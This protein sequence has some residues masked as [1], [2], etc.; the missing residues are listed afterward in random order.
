MDLL[1]HK[2]QI[3]PLELSSDVE[4][5]T[6]LA[7]PLGP[8]TSAEP[9]KEKPPPP[10]TELSDEEIPPVSTSYTLYKCYLFCRISQ[11]ST[12]FYCLLSFSYSKLCLVH[13]VNISIYMKRSH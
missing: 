5:V 2:F 10:P 13:V 3:P 12:S 7:F 9:P 11:D 6:G 4:I 8:P 1:Y